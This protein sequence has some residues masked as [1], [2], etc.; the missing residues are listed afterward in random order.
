MSE[1]TIH[2]Y[3]KEDSEYGIV[4]TASENELTF[5][6]KHIKVTLEELEAMEL[7]MKYS[8]CCHI[9]DSGNLTHDPVKCIAK[10]LETLQ[11]KVNTK[12]RGLRALISEANAMNKPELVTEISATIKKINDFLKKD[13]SNVTDLTQIDTLTCAELDMN[14]IKHYESKIYGI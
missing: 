7:H 6:E 12:T 9:D 13:F 3:I 5:T 2:H 10:R 8:E 1:Q 4:V 14:L 11:T